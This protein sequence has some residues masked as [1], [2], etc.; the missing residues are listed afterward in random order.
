MKKIFL[1]VCLF[2]LFQ[3][4]AQSFKVNYDFVAGGK[5]H[6]TQAT[7]VANAEESSF[8]VQRKFNDDKGKNNKN[9]EN[10]GETKRVS[11]GI[12]HYDL[13]Y[14]NFKSPDFYIEGNT[15][16]DGKAYYKESKS[17]VGW[18]VVE[19]EQKNI[20]GYDCKKAVRKNNSNTHTLVVWFVSDINIPAGPM[21]A[22]GLPGLALEYG[23]RKMEEEEFI[24]YLIANEV[25][26]MAETE[27]IKPN[28][29]AVEM[30][31]SAYIVEQLYFVNKGT[32]N[33][34]KLVGQNA[35]MDKE[36]IDP[37]G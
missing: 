11:L 8:T 30:T 32:Y 9:K 10:V 33:L 6:I 18:E 26:K 36:I 17:N 34:I 15:K 20:L 35:E 24:I 4:H 29:K 2:N 31:K 28:D 25:E 37:E 14:N 27:V 7:L 23:Y 22:N 21:R 3:L 13:I 5:E 12:I 16:K 19:G 1:F